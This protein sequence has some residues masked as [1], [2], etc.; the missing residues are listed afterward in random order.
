MQ[1][2]IHIYVVPLT[3]TTFDK[4]HGGVCNRFTRQQTLFTPSQLASCSDPRPELACLPALNY[5]RAC[6]RDGASAAPTAASQI[7]AALRPQVLSQPSARGLR[8]HL[9][10]TGYAAD[11]AI[12]RSK[13]SR[14]HP[15]YIHI[16]VLLNTVYIFSGIVYT[17]PGIVISPVR[18]LCM[19][20][21]LAACM[22]CVWA[23]RIET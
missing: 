22:A 9:E 17:D 3:G 1:A 7:A 11:P 19:H 10:R 15:V 8:S 6:L 18:M 14:H 2:L 21:A 23:D 13:C 20:A 4:Y 5:Q 12:R 16:Y